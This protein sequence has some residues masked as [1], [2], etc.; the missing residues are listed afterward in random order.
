L[1]TLSVAAEALAAFDEFNVTVEAFDESRVST[2]CPALIMEALND[3]PRFA[4]VEV[5]AT[6]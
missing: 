1:G 6:R 4:G 3:A 5:E 2:S